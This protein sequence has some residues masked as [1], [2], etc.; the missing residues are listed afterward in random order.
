MGLLKEFI[1][2]E[3]DTLINNNL[4]F[5]PIGRLDQLEPSIQ[6][7]LQR[8]VDAT[9]RCSGMVVQIALNYSG[10]QELTDLVRGAVDKASSGNLSPDAVDEDWVVNHLSTRGTPDP[11]LLVRTSGEQRIS[12]FLLWQV[13]YAEIYF[14]PVLWPDFSKI[15]L[16]QAVL[17]YQRRDRRFGGLNPGNGVFTPPGD[18]HGKA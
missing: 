1:R 9:E 4:R 5:R 7:E 10:R 17:E 15:E 11:D 8:A 6:A 3:L 2:R 18:A 12:N 16:L 14:C 13:A